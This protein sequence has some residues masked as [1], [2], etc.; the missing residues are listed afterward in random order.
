MLSLLHACA[1]QPGGG[2]SDLRAATGSGRR[3]IMPTSIGY[4]LSAPAG[5]GTMAPAPAAEAPAP[6][7]AEAP[8]PASRDPPTPSRFDLLQTARSLRGT[9]SPR[10][11]GC[12]MP[13]NLS[14]ASCHP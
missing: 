6:A 12:E 11:V 7:A 3:L 5:R 1:N 9:S 13:N 10:S 14:E 8:A 2:Q 4:P